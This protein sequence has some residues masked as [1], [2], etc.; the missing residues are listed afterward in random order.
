MVYNLLPDY[1][2]PERQI[3]HIRRKTNGSNRMKFRRFSDRHSGNGSAKTPP[4]LSQRG[5]HKTSRSGG[6]R[7]CMTQIDRDLYISLRSRVH[8]RKTPTPHSP[9]VEGQTERGAY[10]NQGKKKTCE[11]KNV[12]FFRNVV[13]ESQRTGLFFGVDAGKECRP[14]SACVCVCVFCFLSS[15]PLARRVGRSLVF[16]FRWLRRESVGER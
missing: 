7:S 9:V 14:F 3:A 16:L 12:F 10:K 5:L 11:K 1:I 6:F 15:T 2:I 13:H 8:G 4:P